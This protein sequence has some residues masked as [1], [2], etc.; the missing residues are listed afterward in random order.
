MESSIIYL[1]E[2]SL[3]CH[4][5]VHATRYGISGRQKYMVTNEVVHA[6]IL[7]FSLKSS[8]FFVMTATPYPRTFFIRLKYK[9]PFIT[10]GKDLDARYEN[11][12]ILFSS[13]GVYWVEK[14]QNPIFPPPKDAARA[15]GPHNYDPNLT[16]NPREGKACLFFNNWGNGVR[17]VRLMTSKDLIHWQDMGSTNIEVVNSNEIRVSPTVIYEEEGRKYYMLLVHA[18]L[19]REEKTFLELFHSSNG[20]YWVKSGEMDISMNI[21]DSR[22]YPWHITVRK[23]GSEYW[24]LASMS[25]GN[26]SRPPM[27]LFFFRSLDLLKWKGYNKPI[28]TPSSGEFDDKM[29]YHGDILIDNGNVYIW[30]SGVSTKNKYSIGLMR[31]KLQEGRAQDLKSDNVINVNDID[32]IET[33]KNNR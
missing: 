1:S 5:K 28:L 18:D 25:H 32:T 10:F 29:I 13:D 16:W 22:Y 12:S 33:V 27:S 8:S 14:T 20:L 6:S 21:G 23:V 30:Y 17:H 2:K 31:G 3:Q 4:V 9:P 7:K 15:R 19:S 11:P 26:L 24:M